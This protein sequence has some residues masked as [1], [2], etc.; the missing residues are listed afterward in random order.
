MGLF[1]TVY[2]QGDGSCASSTFMILSFRVQYHANVGDLGGESNYSGELSD[3]NERE[4]ILLQNKR[5]DSNQTTT[6][7]GL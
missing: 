6:E 2:T 7:K 4:T 1:Q 5:D 3:F